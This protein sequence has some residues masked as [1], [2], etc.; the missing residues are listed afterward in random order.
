M[1]EDFPAWWPQPGQPSVQVNCMAGGVG[2][3][4]SPEG[5]QGMLCS[6]RPTRPFRGTVLVGWGFPGCGAG[7]T[8]R[9]PEAALSCPIL[10]PLAHPSCI[11]ACDMFVRIERQCAGAHAQVRPLSCSPRGAFRLC[12]AQMVACGTLPSV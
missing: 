2:R 4:A 12:C 6:C 9:T 1:V 7:S 5:N 11:C 3:L 8:R 10:L